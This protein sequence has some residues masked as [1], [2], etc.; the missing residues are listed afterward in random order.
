MDV[1]D[2][3]NGTVGLGSCEEVCYSCESSSSESGSDDNHVSVF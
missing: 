2:K 3:E 1:P